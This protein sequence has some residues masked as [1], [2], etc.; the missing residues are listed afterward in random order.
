MEL[1]KTKL[2]DYFT[3]KMGNLSYEIDSETL[4]SSMSY[5]FISK[6]TN[7][8][9]FENFDV[10]YTVT[11]TEIEDFLIKKAEKKELFVDL[12]GNWYDEFKE[13][14]NQKNQ[15]ICRDLSFEF[16]DGSKWIIKILDIVALKD[17]G[18]LEINFED[19]LLLNDVELFDFV[20]ELEWD[21][22]KDL[23]EE[24]QRPQPEPDYGLEWKNCK[25]EIVNWEESIDILD[26]FEI[27]DTIDLDFAQDDK[28]I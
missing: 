20:N 5:Q 16:S 17:D 28:P 25:K 14:H 23:A 6:S 8:Q 3:V 4:I 18:E 27:S 7:S 19:P 11:K 1:M 15:P 24:I 12:F 9:S 26:F 10:I 22:V 13:Y 21:Q 2:P